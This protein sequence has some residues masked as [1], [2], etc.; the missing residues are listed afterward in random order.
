MH[1]IR[2]FVIH[3][4]NCQMIILFQIGCEI[5]VIL[6]MNGH[7]RRGQAF[8]ISQIC[9]FVFPNEMAERLKTHTISHSYFRNCFP[10]ISFHNGIFQIFACNYVTVTVN[11]EEFT[12][13]FQVM[14]SLHISDKSRLCSPVIRITVSF[15]ISPGS[16]CFGLCVTIITH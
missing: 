2:I 15:S 9:G 4:L 12:S 7:C 16:I 3:I 10:R 11:I 13:G 8:V 6:I 5:G 1:R 14:C